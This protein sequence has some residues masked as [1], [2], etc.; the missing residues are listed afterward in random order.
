MEGK[1]CPGPK[2]DGARL[3]LY[4]WKYKVFVRLPPGAKEE[5]NEEEAREN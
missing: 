4:K 2:N 3:A 1:K 5:L